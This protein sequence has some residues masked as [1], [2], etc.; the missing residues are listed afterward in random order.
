M[1][2]FVGLR[3]ALEKFEKDGEYVKC[4]KWS[5]AKSEYDFLS[6]EIYYEGFTVLQCV[7]GK[8]QG[9]Y[10]PIDDFTEETEKELIKRV[11]Y[12]YTE[13]QYNKGLEIVKELWDKSYSEY[14]QMHKAD[15][16]DIIELTNEAISYCMER[17]GIKTVA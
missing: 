5:I 3:R 12:I 4:G 14:I 10:R 1:I 11:K 8:L 15:G 7:D 16:K 13:L 6:W 9:G 17:L 2:S